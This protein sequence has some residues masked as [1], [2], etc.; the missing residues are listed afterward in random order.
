[1]KI[2]QSKYPKGT[3]P[4][5]QT[6]GRYI[7]EN[8]YENLKILAKTI[9]NDMTFMAVVSTSTLEVGSGKSVFVQQTAEAWNSLVESYHNI[10][11]DFTMKNLVFK[12]ED[13]IHR[14]FELPKYSCIIL[15]EWEDANYWSK[16]AMTL[17]QFFR[18]CRQLNLFILVICPNYFQMPISYA[19]TR[20]IFFVDVRFEGEFERGYFSFYNFKKK[21]ELYLKGKKTMDY[22]VVTPDFSGRFL[23]GYIIDR[24]EY[25]K[26]KYK[27]MIDNE[28]KGKQPTEK[29][30]KINLFKQIRERLKG[31]LTDSQLAD[32]FGISK[33]TVYRWIHNDFNDIS[34]ENEG[35]MDNVA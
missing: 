7:D 1:M 34:L 28:E 16:L 33:R 2:L 10:K 17:R 5:Q 24:N 22:S 18:K 20:S 8:Y 26:A 31:K 12:P 11:L 35:D 23:D 21:R 19:I 4:H 15:D 6:D 14:A 29:D 3:F 9:V 32:G 25:Q 13:L 27:D 30:I